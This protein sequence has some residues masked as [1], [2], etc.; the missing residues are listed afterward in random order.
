[1]DYGDIED[2]SIRELDRKKVIELL[3]NLDVKPLLVFIKENNFTLEDEVITLFKKIGIPNHLKGYDCLMKAIIIMINYN[4]KVSITKKLYPKIA[5][6]LHMNTKQVE[7]NIRK[8][9]EVTWTNIE[10]N[11]IDKIF[12]YT[13]S[14]D[15]DHPTNSH[16]IITIAK[17]IL[18]KR[19]RVD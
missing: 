6:E 19:K 14:I 16:F 7:K 18:K 5:N 3:D 17:Y 8:A 12:G 10:P 11:Q 2:Y 15:K 4:F 9:I 13:I 1:M